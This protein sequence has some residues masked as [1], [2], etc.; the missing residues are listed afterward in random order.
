M[1]LSTIAMLR[2]VERLRA[3]ASLKQNGAD[4][5]EPFTIHLDLGPR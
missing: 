5:D 4:D 1:L 2:A 3:F